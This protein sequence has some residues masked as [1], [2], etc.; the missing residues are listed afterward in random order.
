MVP[1][2]ME[3]AGCSA[4]PMCA[5]HPSHGPFAPHQGD[6][7]KNEGAEV[8]DHERPTAVLGRLH[9]KAQ[10]VTQAHGIASHGQDETHTG[11]PSFSMTLFHR[12]SFRLYLGVS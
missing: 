6:G 4:M 11:V 3:N 2:Q 12:S 1:E 9:R 5:A 8:G 10:V 7:K